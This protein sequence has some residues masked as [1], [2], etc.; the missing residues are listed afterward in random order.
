MMTAEEDV[1]A[2]E[3]AADEAAAEEDVA[4]DEDA[5]DEEAAEASRSS[6][7]KASMSSS[8]PLPLLD[9]TQSS[10]SISAL[11][12]AAIKNASSAIQLA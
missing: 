3:D 11:P 2:D 9:R 7:I 6:P 8:Q 4:V 10:T 5:A 1:A 12:S